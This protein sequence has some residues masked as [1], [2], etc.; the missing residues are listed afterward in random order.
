MTVSQSTISPPV[1]QGRELNTHYTASFLSPGAQHDLMAWLEDDSQVLWHVERFKL[2]GKSLR[3]PRSLCWFGDQGLNYRYTGTDHI[4]NGWPSQLATVRQQVEANVGSA[5]N[6]LLINR[7][8][9]GAQYMGWHRDDERG[10]SPLIASLSLGAQRRFKIRPSYE[11]SSTHTYDL[12]G[13]SLITFDGRNQHMLC[14]T[15]RPCA[16]RINLTFRQI[17]LDDC[18]ILG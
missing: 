15:K 1:T 13:G 6:Y 4:A 10:A 14:K 9:D 2:F 11:P 5:F 17:N 16:P 3:V 8:Q 12:A 18:R 7:Y